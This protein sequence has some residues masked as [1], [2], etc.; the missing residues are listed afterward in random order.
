M[1]PNQPIEHSPMPVNGEHLPIP[2]TAAPASV[3]SEP[4]SNPSTPVSVPDAPPTPVPAPPPAAPSPGSNPADADDVDVIEKEW[5]DRAEEV[6]K[7]TA[8]DP[9]R[10]EEQV[11]D[12]QIDYM[13]KRFGKDIKKSE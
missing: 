5:V 7:D 10:E 8:G 1:E 13:K 11:E 2:E 9:Y 6:I 3:P 12:L 4:M